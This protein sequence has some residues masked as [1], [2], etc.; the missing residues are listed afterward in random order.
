MGGFTRDRLLRPAE[1]I[2]RYQLLAESL[3]ELDKEGVEIISQILPAFP[4]V[5]WWTTLSKLI[6]GPKRYR[7]LLS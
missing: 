3:T 6:R 7:E 5:F 4:M 2:Q 1:R